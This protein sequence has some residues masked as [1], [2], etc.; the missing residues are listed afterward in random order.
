MVQNTE[1]CLCK[2]HN[3]H[4]TV[5]NTAER[6]CKA[7]NSWGYSGTPIWGCRIVPLPCTKSRNVFT[8]F[9]TTIY[10]CGIVPP[11]VPPKFLVPRFWWFCTF[12][13]VWCLKISPQARESNGVNHLDRQYPWFFGPLI[14]I[15]FDFFHVWCLK[16]S[17]RVRESNSVNH[18]FR[19]Y[20]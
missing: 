12:F 7:R 13:R 14:L 16:I 10:G 19:W 6:L 4:G 1:E 9:G 2:A 20:T 11:P 18:L 15:I 5:E 17:T 8:R 3:N